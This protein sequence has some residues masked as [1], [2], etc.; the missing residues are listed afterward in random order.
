MNARLCPAQNKCVYVVRPLIGVYGLKI[1]NM[2][3]DVV[4]VGNS[5]PTMHVPRYPRNIERFTCIIP[6]QYG[7]VLDGTFVFV[8]E[9]ART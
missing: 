8:H 4:L 5:V 7:D 2:A 3:D 6:F 1:K 9:T